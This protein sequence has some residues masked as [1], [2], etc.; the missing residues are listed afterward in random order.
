MRIVASIQ[1]PSMVIGAILSM[2]ASFGCVSIGTHERRMAEYRALLAEHQQLKVEFTEAQKQK[3]M[4]KKELSENLEEQEE[5]KREIVEKEIK[6]TSI[7]GT[8]DEL[9]NEL[10]EDIARGSVGVTSDGDNLKINLEGKVLFPSGSD[11]LQPEGKRIL[12]RVANVLKKVHDKNI[13]VEGHTD[14]LRLVGNVQKRFQN[15][16]VLSAYRSAAVVHFLQ[17]KGIDPERLF[18]AAYGE[19]RPVDDNATAAG[20]QKNRRVEISLVPVGPAE[21]PPAE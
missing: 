12:Q 10:K 13:R 3:E 9:V 1:K 2:T 18:V 11:R 4:M 20:R 8:Y 15:N 5:L 21:A 14:N 6:I 17:S 19:Y 7:R 16:W